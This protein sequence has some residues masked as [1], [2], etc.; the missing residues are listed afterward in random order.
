MFFLVFARA[1]VDVERSRCWHRG[2]HLAAAVDTAEADVDANDIA[3]AEMAA[4]D[5]L[6]A[7][8]ILLLLAV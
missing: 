4:R 2:V 1:T 8:F 3:A 7:T 5:V 6:A